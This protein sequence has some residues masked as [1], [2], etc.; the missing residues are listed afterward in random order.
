MKSILK[1]LGKNRTIAMLTAIMVYF[2]IVTFHDEITQLAIKA[3]NA[4]GRDQYNDYLGYFFLILL[5]LFLAWFV[6]NIYK[7]ERKLLNVIL[8][9]TITGVM[10]FSFR[11]LMVYNI[12]AIHFV[13]YA[14]VAI[15][16]LPVFKSYGET[17]FW[18]TLLGVVDELFQYF[19]LVPEFEYFDFNDNV[20]NL[21]GAGAGIILVHSLGGNAVVIK[22]ITWYRSP[23]VITG[24]TILVLFF[25]LLLT[26]KMTINPTGIPGSEN[27]FSLNREIM[28]EGEFWKEAYP[29]RRFHILRP[30]EGMAVMY[31]LFAGF[32]YLDYISHRFHRLK[33]QIITDN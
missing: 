8:V 6:W 28:P 24:L 15:I 3:R 1:W 10:I 26:G 2:S 23:A 12:E 17:V 32:F 31:L 18:V 33:T 19:F 22:K 13:E 9:V 4:I 21:V 29:G 5:L 20:L 30:W 7:S 11:F 16:L 27:W 14:I 25:L